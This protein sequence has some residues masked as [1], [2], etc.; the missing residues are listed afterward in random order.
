MTTHNVRRA[1][2]LFTIEP[3]EREAMHDY[4]TT[5][6][7]ARA[8]ADEL[9]RAAAVT[10]AIRRAIHPSLDARVYREQMGGGRIGW[11]VDFGRFDTVDGPKL[12]LT[13]D[14]DYLDEE[15]PLY[16]LGIYDTRQEVPG[17]PE[18]I[19]ERTTYRVEGRP[20]EEIAGLVADRAAFVYRLAVPVED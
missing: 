20:P 5:Y 6:D 17:G 9:N 1:G 4:W 2:E 14:T 10:Q 8:R 19:I 11:A 3:P 15:T 16:T 13:D 12:I 7:A 18:P